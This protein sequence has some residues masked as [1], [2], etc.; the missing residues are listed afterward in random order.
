MPFLSQ[1]LRAL[2]EDFVL[3]LSFLTRLPLR[4]TMSGPV[5]AVELARS[6]RVYPAIGAAIGLATGLALALGLWAGLPAWPAAVLAL[7][8]Q[9]ALTGALHED[10]L[11]DVAD[12]FGG[13]RDRAAKLAIMRDSHIGTYGVLALV[14]SVLLRASAL[15]VLA[16]ASLDSGDP[17]TLLAVLAAV[18]ALSRAG[19]PL[20]MRALPPARSDGIGKA[21]GRPSVSVCAIAIGTALLITALAITPVLGLTA[22]AAVALAAAGLAWL[23]RAQIGGYTGDVLGAAQQVAEIAA[24][25]T[26]ASVA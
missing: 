17:A 15:A 14:A 9:M 12:G 13:G 1:N 18:G 16:D 21:H 7:T 19:L 10:G 5:T 22:V 20:V 3:A 8:A 11:A 2:G 25:L 23:A 26:M 24:L 6:L 4:L